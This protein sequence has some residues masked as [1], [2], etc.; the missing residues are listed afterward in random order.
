MNSKLLQQQQQQPAVACQQL[1]HV[2]PV[3]SA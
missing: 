3:R 1:I 2:Q